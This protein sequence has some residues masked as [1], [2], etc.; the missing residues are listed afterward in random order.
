MWKTVLHKIEYLRSQEYLRSTR[1]RIYVCSLVCPPTH[2]GIQYISINSISI[3]STFRIDIGIFKCKFL[4]WSQTS[5]YCILFLSCSIKRK[6]YI[7]VYVCLL[8]FNL[9]INSSQLFRFC[10]LLIQ[11]T[12]SASTFNS[13]R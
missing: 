8:L 1:H 11:S 4:N 7:Y 5:I 13:K 6:P 10:K 2:I 12:F 9:L 3:M